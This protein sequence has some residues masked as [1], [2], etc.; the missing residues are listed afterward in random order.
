MYA[1]R[2]YYEPNMPKLCVMPGDGIGQEVIPA[3][4]AVL[5]DGKYI[6]EMPLSSF[7]GTGV[8]VDIPKKKWEIITAEDLS[9]NF[10]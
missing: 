5:Q 7:Y 9:Y 8:V 1:I 3:A 2:S 4:V 6:D 10:V